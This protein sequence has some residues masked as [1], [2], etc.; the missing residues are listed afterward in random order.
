MGGD[1]NL[2]KTSLLSTEKTFLH[3][4]NT[5]QYPTQNT[6]KSAYIAADH[7]TAIVETTIAKLI[8]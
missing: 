6:E 7:G 5:G 2:L 8:I 4:D 3:T 1:L